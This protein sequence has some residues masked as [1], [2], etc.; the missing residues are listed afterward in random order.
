MS[1]R[2]EQRPGGEIALLGR[3]N[4][5]T[6]LDFRE[7]MLAHLLSRPGSRVVFDLS[8]LQIDGSVVLAL[9]VDILRESKKLGTSVEYRACPSSV[10]KIAEL[11][12]V[13]RI[14]P[15]VA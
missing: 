11:S 13:E 14:L 12:G 5:E 15:L 2:L 10:I 3:V 7:Q 8:S 6:V 1:N 9:L 4:V